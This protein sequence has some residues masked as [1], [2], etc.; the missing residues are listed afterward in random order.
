MPLTFPDGQ[1]F[2]TGAAPYGYRSATPQETTPRVVLSV[3]IEGFKTEAMVDTGGVFLVCHPEVALQ[4]R[5][6]TSD[7]VSDTLEILFRGV[8]VRG[9]L[10]RLNLTLVAEI[11]TTL[12]FQATVFVPESEDAEQWG[13]IPSILGMYGC[14]ER[15]RFAVDPDTETF[16]FGP[17]ASAS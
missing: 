4:A 1:A 2:A 17:T 13:E 5:L 3:E 6:E 14:L 11:G 10:Y 8:F 12:D 7:A 16:Y 9:R 15:I